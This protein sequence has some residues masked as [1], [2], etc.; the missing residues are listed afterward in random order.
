MRRILAAAVLAAALA[1]TAGCA[2]EPPPVSE[3]V[4]AAYDK[5]ATTKATIAPKP[6]ST[7]QMTVFIG[8]SYTAGAGSTQGAW[9]DRMAPRVK[10]K[11]E[12]LALGGTGYLREGANRACGLAECPN[13]RGVIPEVV[14]VKP[15]RVVVAGGRND[16]LLNQD[17]VRA[18]AAAFYKELSVKLPDAEI[19]ALSP[20]WDAT[21]PPAEL[22]EIAESVRQAVTAVGGSYV[23]IGQP[24]AGHPELLSED[25]VHPND[26]GHEALA[27]AAQAALRKAGLV[28][29]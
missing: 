16:V 8:D 29:P 10:W 4:Q 11:Y 6:T 17:E 25:K 24:L 22:A 9:P 12:N 3:K 2:H 20:V 15:S 18:S 7:P 13:Y 1:T 28:K 19:I 26:A 23:D 21:E 27:V 5:L 14:K